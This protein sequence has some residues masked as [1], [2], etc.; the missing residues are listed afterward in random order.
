[1]AGRDE[2]AGHG[3]A[4]LAE[5]DESDVHGSSLFLVCLEGWIGLR[6]RQT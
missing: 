6:C 5:A 1:M 4:H 2:A 3:Q